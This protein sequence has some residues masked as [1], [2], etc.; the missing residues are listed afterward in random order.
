MQHGYA[1]LR[2]ARGS[3]PKDLLVNGEPFC[4]Y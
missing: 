4:G 3:S 2:L 1:R